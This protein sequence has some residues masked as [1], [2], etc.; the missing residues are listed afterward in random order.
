M[1]I[2]VIVHSQSGNTR[3]FADSIFDKLT[4][5]GH[6]VNLTQLETSTPVKGGNVR[7]KMDIRFTNLPNIDDADIVMFGGPVWAFSPSPVIIAAMEQLANLKAKKVVNFATMGF[8][9]KG[10]GGKA[11]LAWMNRTVGTLGAK[12][13]YSSICCQMFH[14][15]PAEIARETELIAQ[16]IS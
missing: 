3:K 2:A 6:T 15:L 9:L 5:N 7:Q 13:L 8:P 16:H 14:N 10:M 1:K 12:V 11:A 4:S